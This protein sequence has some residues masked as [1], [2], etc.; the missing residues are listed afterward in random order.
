MDGD[1]IVKK[2][3]IFSSSSNQLV[4]GLEMARKLKAMRERFNDI[5]NDTNNFEFEDHP[6]VIQAL[7]RGNHKSHLFVCDEE[8]ILRGEDKKAVISLLLDFK[9]E[10]KAFF[11]SIVGIGGLGKTTLAQYVY[12]D[13]NVKNYF[14]L[15]MWVCVSDVFDL[16]TIVEKIIRSATSSNFGNLEM[17]Q[18]QNE[19]RKNLNQKKY[20]LV[21]DNVWNEDNENWCNLKRLLIGGAKGSKVVITTRTKL[22]AEITSTISPYF[23]KGLSKNQSWSLLKQMAFKKE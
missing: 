3:R 13:E 15:K 10:E 1:K 18:L 12:N 11:I 19:F 14:E 8:V 7:I 4:F 21:L 9:V 22:V 5:A 2:V 17:D 16:K 20:L 6:L 23:L